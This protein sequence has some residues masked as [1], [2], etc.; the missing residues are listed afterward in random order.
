MYLLIRHS[1][2]V[3]VGNSSTLIL[4]G[5]PSS[6]VDSGSLGSGHSLVAFN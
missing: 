3:G 4:R 2:V 1:T 6:R 5:V